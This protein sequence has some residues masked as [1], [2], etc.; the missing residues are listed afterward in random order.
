MKKLRFILIIFI[1]ILGCDRLKNLSGDYVLDL[2]DKYKLWRTSPE[3]IMITD[4]SNTNIVGP[5]I[6]KINMY[7]NCVFGLVKK[8]EWPQDS[9]S[10]SGY[11]LLNITNLLLKFN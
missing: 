6:V 3:Q 7:D 10:V 9:G 11:F 8:P 2:D 1:F 5:V 4:E